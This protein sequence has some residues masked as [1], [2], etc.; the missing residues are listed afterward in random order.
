MYKSKKL[1]KVDEKSRV[2]MN[3]SEVD[4]GLKEASAV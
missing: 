2:M 4:K 1:T 3:F